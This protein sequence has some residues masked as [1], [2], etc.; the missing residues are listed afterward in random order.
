[1]LCVRLARPFV[2]KKRQRE[3][4]RRRIRK[5]ENSR[6]DPEFEH[7]KRSLE[8]KFICASCGW[9][10][11]RI[12]SRKSKCLHSFQFSRVPS[13]RAESMS[14]FSPLNK[15][16]ESSITHKMDF[17]SNVNVIRCPG[18][19]LGLCALLFLSLYFIVD[20]FLLSST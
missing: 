8:V 9:V 12:I 19:V 3:R 17:F 11:Q 1:M 6:A 16:V 5:V 4:R 10:F 18:R 20:K 7:T 15:R 2:Q 14:S 13:R